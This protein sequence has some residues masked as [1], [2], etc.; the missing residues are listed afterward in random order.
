M[1][2]AVTVTSPVGPRDAE[3]GDLDRAVLAEQHVGRLDVPVHDAGRV[4]RG[5][6]GRRPARRSWRPPAAAACP[7]RTSTAARLFDGRYSMISHG[8]PSSSATS[9]TVIA[10]GCCRRAAMR[11]SR[12]HLRRASSA[13]ADGQTRLQQQLLDRDRAVQPLVVRLPDD[14]HRA[15]ADALAQPVATG[16]Q[17]AF[18]G[19][20]RTL[21][22]GWKPINTMTKR[23]LSG[24]V[25]RELSRWRR[26]SWPD[27]LV[28][29]VVVVVVVVGGG[30]RGGGCG[31]CR[32]RGGRRSWSCRCW[33]SAW[34]AVARWCVV[35][36]V[37]RTG[38]SV[39]V[40][41]VRRAGRPV[42]RVGVVPGATA[43][44]ATNQTP[45]PTTIAST[46]APIT[47]A[48]RDRRIGRTA[49]LIAGRRRDRGP[50]MRV[51]SGLR[52]SRRRSPRR[53]LAD[54]H[55]RRSR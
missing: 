22:Y 39:E 29:V 47:R 52:I 51:R 7:A 13:W 8:W 5:Q 32:C 48:A 42:H 15:T 46:R 4:R 14:A 12:M 44:V 3:V 37:W 53:V 28:V 43:R 50:T 24:R 49:A 23:T 40:W 18:L 27:L 20:Q 45:K 9:Y 31:G 1:P 16:D 10:L 25:V 19:G 38:G 34:S 26:L 41:I 11:P 55:G 21:P 54:Q 2:V 17:T 30:R 36:S 33:S 35:V 6:R